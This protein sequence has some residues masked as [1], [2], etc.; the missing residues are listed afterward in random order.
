L[1]D[2]EEEER[3]D[4]GVFGTMIVS[5]PLHTRSIKTG[6]YPFGRLPKAR[7]NWSRRKPR[8][9]YLMMVLMI[10]VAALPK[11]KARLLFEVP[12]VPTRSIMTV[13]VSQ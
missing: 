10:G 1:D 4:V 3:H 5:T 7:M 12:G 6:S 2:T 11:G 8:Y 13:V 9:M